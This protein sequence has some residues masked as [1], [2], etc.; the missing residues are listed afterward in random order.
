MAVELAAAS[1][2]LVAGGLL[3]ADGHS[4]WQH[5][6]FVVCSRLVRGTKW[7][8]ASCLQLLCWWLMAAGPLHCC[9]KRIK[10][11]IE[12]LININIGST[13]GRSHPT[14]SDSRRNVGDHKCIFVSVEFF[15]GLTSS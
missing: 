15:C 8:I 2:W 4:R 13:N 6:E 7:E 11:T 10:S 3:L 12:G 5:W 14:N 1:S 9:S